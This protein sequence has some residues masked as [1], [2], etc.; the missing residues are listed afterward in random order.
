MST[1]PKA[2]MLIRTS[3][4]MLR[5]MRKLRQARRPIGKPAQA[6]ASAELRSNSG[7]P[8]PNMGSNSLKTNPGRISAAPTNARVVSRRPS[9]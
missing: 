8:T 6:Q 1:A 7:P 5:L 9:R 3:M 4:V 2:A